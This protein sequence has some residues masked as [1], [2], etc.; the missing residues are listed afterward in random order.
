M[1]RPG[2]P[3]W[4]LI[5][6]EDKHADAARDIVAEVK[7]SVASRRTMESIAKTGTVWRSNR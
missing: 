6:H 7:T 2:R 5:K 3:Q 1:K 4:L